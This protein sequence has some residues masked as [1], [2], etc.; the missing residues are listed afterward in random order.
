MII[1]LLISNCL[2]FPTLER[3]APGMHK[4]VFG[5]D[6]IFELANGN[7]YTVNGT[8][9]K[10]SFGIVYSAV[11]LAPT[12][13]DAIAI[14]KIMLKAPDTLEAECHGQTCENTLDYP[15]H[16]T[17]DAKHPYICEVKALERLGR[18]VAPP[19]IDGN[20]VYIPNTIIPG[21]PIDAFLNGMGV[22]EARRYIRIIFHAA[23][24]AMQQLHYS[25]IFHG[26][27]HPFNLH[28]IL[29]DGLVTVEWLDF[30]WTV[31][32]PG[33]DIPSECTTYSELYPV[34]Y[35]KD[36]AKFQSQYER[37]I[38]RPFYPR[39][40]GEEVGLVGCVGYERVHTFEPYEN[41]MPPL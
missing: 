28:V 2:S 35:R 27:A 38:C 10:G 39:E 15:A 34:Y 3:R 41:G 1:L 36:V 12:I 32:T 24:Y 7:T 31:L 29:K 33:R 20:I 19:V 22:N 25:G 26:D 18:L 9:G 21:M 5:S 13:G 11:P 23:W 14:K 17:N 8:L 30:G 16:V 4:S 37:K 6:T 40:N